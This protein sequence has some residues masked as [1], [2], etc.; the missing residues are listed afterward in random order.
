MRS[1]NDR[2]LR[3]DHCGSF[4]RPAVL[5][6]ARKDHYFG[7]LGFEELRAVEDKAIREVI[8]LQRGAGIEIVTDGEFR[9]RFWFSG[10]YESLG[11]L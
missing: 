3:A 5:R 8:A 7:R 11:K 4:I 6:Q 2:A 9:R 10:L 1:K